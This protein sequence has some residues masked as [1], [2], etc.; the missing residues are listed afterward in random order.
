MFSGQHVGLGLLRCPGEMIP[1]LDLHTQLRPLRLVAI[2]GLRFRHRAELVVLTSGPRVN[3]ERVATGR[4]DPRIPRVRHGPPCPY[5]RADP[6][7]SAARHRNLLNIRIIRILDSLTHFGRINDGIS[8][9]GRGLNR[10]S[11]RVNDLVRQRLASLGVSVLRKALHRTRKHV[12]VDGL[13]HSISLQVPSWAA[14]RCSWR[15]ALA[16]RSK[17]AASQLLMRS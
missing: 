8:D 5:A 13:V 2:N 12:I 6:K 15:K 17:Q 1:A 4:K 9:G 11:K 14:V 16:A 10:Q 7:Q 3:S